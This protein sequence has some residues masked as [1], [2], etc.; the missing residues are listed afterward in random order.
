MQVVLVTMFRPRWRGKNAS[1]SHGQVL[2]RASFLCSNS[3]SH[4]NSFK[5]SPR[6]EIRR[7]DGRAG[8]S[9]SKFDK[10][11]YLQRRIIFSSINNFHQF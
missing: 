7:L 6:V 1:S 9:S 8:R 3:N 2:N 5:F 11:L 4:A 10:N